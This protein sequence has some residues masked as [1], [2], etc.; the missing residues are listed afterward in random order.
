MLFI[1]ITLFEKV[2]ERETVCI[3]M[4]IFFTLFCFRSS[5]EVSS[6]QNNISIGLLDVSF[7]QLLDLLYP[8]PLVGVVVLLVRIGGCVGD[9]D[10]HGD[11]GGGVDSNS[12]NSFARQPFAVRHEV[13]GVAVIGV[14]VELGLIDWVSADNNGKSLTIMS[15]LSFI[16]TS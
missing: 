7:H 13:H 9:E 12:A 14:G 11:I 6:K 3:V 16:F 8:V 10:V 4:I 15:Q 5:I 1:P 2:K